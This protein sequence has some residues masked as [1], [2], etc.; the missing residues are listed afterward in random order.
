MSSA[1]STPSFSVSSL[2]TAS[3]FDQLMLEATGSGS[4][5]R[6]HRE[7]RRLGTADDGQVDRHRVGPGRDP[8]DVDEA[9]RQR[10]A[11]ADHRRRGHPCRRGCRSLGSARPRGTRRPVRA[12]PRWRRTDHLHPTRPRRRPRR[13]PSDCATIPGALSAISTSFLSPFGDRPSW[14]GRR[15]R[16]ERTTRT[17]QSHLAENTAL[18][19]VCYRPA[20][21]EPEENCGTG[22][23]SRR[24][25]RSTERNRDRAPPRSRA[26]RTTRAA[27]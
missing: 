19:G 10:L 6:V 17:C 1:P 22:Q 12:R 18:Y 4:P 2:A 20:G 16:S 27:L 7:E 25:R 15:R 14:P 13:P 26:S 3:L 21:R 11:R 23:V 9:E 24:R 5:G 8:G